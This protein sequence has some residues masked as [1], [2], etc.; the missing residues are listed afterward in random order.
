M[1]DPVRIRPERPPGETRNDKFRL[2]AKQA[3]PDLAEKRAQRV[4]SCLSSLGNLS[5]ASYEYSNEVGRSS[6]RPEAA[7]VIA[8]LPHGSSPW[9]EGPR[10]LEEAERR[11][12]RQKPEKPH[13][14]FESGRSPASP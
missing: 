1:S 10:G 8:A 3:W 2:R 5:A 7:Q 14:A 6:L 12:L 13:F 4:L 11:L 9:A